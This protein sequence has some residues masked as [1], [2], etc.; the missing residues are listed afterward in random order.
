MRRTNGA[1][2]SLR[3]FISNRINVLFL[4]RRWWRYIRG[5]AVSKPM[6]LRLKKHELILF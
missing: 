6:D 1:P 4:K 3:T 2:G 5:T